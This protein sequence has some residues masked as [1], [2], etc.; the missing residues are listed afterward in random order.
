MYTSSIY[1]HNTDE[2]VGYSIVPMHYPDIIPYNKTLIQYTN[3]KN[4]Y[5]M[6]YTH[7]ETTLQQIN[8]K[9]LLYHDRYQILVKPEKV[10]QLLYDIVN[11]KGEYLI[12]I[13]LLEYSSNNNIII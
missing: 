10:K 4:I 6:Y 7:I 8:R 13:I 5:E 9:I 11:C 12:D 1:I 3:I 2:L